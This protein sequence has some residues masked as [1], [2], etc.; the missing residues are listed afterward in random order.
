M[1]ELN[2]L[3]QWLFSEGYTKENYPDDVRPFAP[4]YGGFT[5]R[6]ETLYQLVFE[7]PCG[8]LVE[9]GHF[10]GGVMS[11]MG[12]HWMPE[13]NNPVVTCPRFVKAPCERNHPLLRE[14][15]GEILHCACH[16]AD[17]P[18]SYEQSLEKAHA[19]VWKEAD[20]LFETLRLQKQGWACK[21]RSRY[22][23]MEKQWRMFYD[24]IDCAREGFC[25]YCDVLQAELSPKKGNV[26]YDVKI[27]R[28]QKGVGLFPDETVVS[29]IKG[30]KLLDSS[31]SLTLCEAIV[32]CCGAQI[33]ESE[34]NRSFRERFFD[35]T[36]TV[37]V[38]NIRA[39]RKSVV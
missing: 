18:Y 11:F 23:R 6:P 1:D 24:P 17:R 12:I 5:Y 10:V 22:N 8:L 30:K 38:Q 35:P 20:T 2:K 19:E 31:A 9:G 13:N 3:T 28:T 26:F 14:R 25:R 4:F 39:D 33:Q 36:Y 37:Q 15:R 29:I 16:L 21:H 27:S 34:E 7:T 32:R